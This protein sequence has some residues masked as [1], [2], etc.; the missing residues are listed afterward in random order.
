MVNAECCGLNDP[1]CK[2]EY[3]EPFHVHKFSPVPVVV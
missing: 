3:A 2:T 1:A